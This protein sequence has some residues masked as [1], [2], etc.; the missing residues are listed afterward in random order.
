MRILLL[1]L[2]IMLAGCFG[3][4]TASINIAENAV[5]LGSVKIDQRSADSTTFSIPVQVAKD[6]SVGQGQQM[7]PDAI[8][9]LLEQSKDEEVK[10][11][12]SDCLGGN[13]KCIAAVADSASN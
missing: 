3:Q 10:A 7:P 2:G 4:K 12:L 6:M 1:G 11:D 5:V 9:Q 8:K 13:R